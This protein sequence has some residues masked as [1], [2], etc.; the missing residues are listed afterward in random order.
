MAEVKPD[1]SPHCTPRT[2]L[3][4]SLLQRPQN[5]VALLSRDWHHGALEGLGIQNINNFQGTLKGRGVSGGG[6][7]GQPSAGL[8]S[9]PLCH[10]P[11]H[12]LGAAGSPPSRPHRQTDKGPD[13]GTA[14]PAPALRAHS[15]SGPAPPESEGLSAATC[16][17]PHPE[18][19]PPGGRREQPAHARPPPQPLTDLHPAGVQARGGGEQGVQAAVQRGGAAAQRG[20]L[21]LQLAEDVPGAARQVGQLRQQAHQG[22]RADLLQRAEERGA[23]GPRRPGAHGPLVEGHGGRA[24][25]QRGPAGGARLLLGARGRQGRAGLRSPH[26]PA[27]GGNTSAEPLRAGRGS[28][29]SLQEAGKRRRLLPSLAIGEG[30]GSGGSAADT[31]E[32][33]GDERKGEEKGAGRS[34]LRRP[35]VRPRPAPSDSTASAWAPGPLPPPRPRRLGSVPGPRPP[36]RR[37]QVARSGGGGSLARAAHLGGSPA[38]LPAATLSQARPAP[39][40]TPGTSGGPQVS[41]QAVSGRRPRLLRRFGGPERVQH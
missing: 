30:G 22:A 29:R 11:R 38:L 20:R 33:E 3:S 24:A 40:E 9:S 35:E 19:Q 32:R 17:R 23:R 31:G 6:M 34:H 8:G 4:I 1:S 28:R 7:A 36:A 5:M 18:A 41:P 27:R 26:R 16:R 10:H 12:N 15:S 21:A 37:G 25:G 13:S 14:G 2:F 39:R